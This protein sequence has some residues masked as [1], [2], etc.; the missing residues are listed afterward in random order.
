M[1]YRPPKTKSKRQ[2]WTSYPVSRSDQPA[3]KS[4]QL[5]EIID[6]GIGQIRGTW[7]QLERKELHGPYGKQELLGAIYSVYWRWDEGDRGKIRC[8]LAS[9]LSGKAIKRSTHLVELLIKGALPDEVEPN[10]IKIWVDTI[11]YGEANHVRPFKLRG[12][13]YLK[14]GLVRC[15]RLYRVDQEG[16]GAGRRMSG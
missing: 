3:E 13:F 1:K 10:V 9:L 15:A 6:R 2:Q 5:D 4:N 7:D 16:S 14:G 12:F 8:R 11:R